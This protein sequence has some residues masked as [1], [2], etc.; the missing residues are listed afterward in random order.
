MSFV[1]HDTVKS[2]GSLPRRAGG[3]ADLTCVCVSMFAL[4]EAQGPILEG[5]KWLA[6]G[7]SRQGF[8]NRRESSPHGS[9]A[10]P[11]SGGF[12]E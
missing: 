2:S 7:A 1:L 6:L 10:L 9:S 12:K 11:G 4:S 8:T 5:D 3:I